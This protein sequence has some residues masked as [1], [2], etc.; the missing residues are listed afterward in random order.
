MQMPKGLFD[1]YC[2]LKKKKYGNKKKSR[3][4]LQQAITLTEAKAL[5]NDHKSH[6]SKLFNEENGIQQVFV[7]I[8]ILNTYYA[9]TYLVTW[10]KRPVKHTSAK[11]KRLNP[12]IIT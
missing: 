10:G 7:H 11:Q 4:T 12:E 9:F 1:Y 2:W 5:T 3:G 6:E 8:C